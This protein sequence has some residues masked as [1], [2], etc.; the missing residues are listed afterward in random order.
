[1]I[2]AFLWQPVT[3]LLLFSVGAYLIFFICNKAFLKIEQVKITQ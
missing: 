2:A 1:M 3:F